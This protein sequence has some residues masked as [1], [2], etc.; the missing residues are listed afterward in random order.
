[1]ANFQE[2]ETRVERLEREVMMLKMQLKTTLPLKP[3]TPEELSRRR[4]VAAKILAFAESKRGTGI[5]LS[6]IVMEWR[7]RWRE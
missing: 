2:L 4:Q 1:M 6:D 5:T 3:P 7:E